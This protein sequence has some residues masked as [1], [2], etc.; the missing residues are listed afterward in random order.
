MKDRIIYALTIFT[1]LLYIIIANNIVLKGDK[2]FDEDEAS[3][4]FLSEVQKVISKTEL[5]YGEI[6]VSFEAKILKGEHKNEIVNALQIIDPSSSINYKELEVGE[7]IYL[8]KQTSDE[9]TIWYADQYDRA[10]GLIILGIVFIGFVLIF[11]RKK[12]VNTI[13][14]LIFTCLSIFMVYIPA[15]IKG[16]NIYFWSIITCI[17]IGVST[18][19]I[20]QGPTRKSFAAMFGCL[21]GTAISGILTLIMSEILS[22]TGMLNEESLYLYYMNA[23]NPIDLKGIIFG[24]IIVGAIGAIMDVSIDIASS[25]NE[26][27]NASEKPTF[28]KTIKAGFEIGRDIIGTMANTLVL[29]YIGSSLSC[30]LLTVSYSG[31][32][33]YLLNR[34]MIVVEM[35]Q[36][37]VG[38]LGIFLAIPLTT[39]ISA[40]LYLKTNKNHKFLPVFRKKEEKSKITKESFKENPW[41]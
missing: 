3:R 12:G 29:A 25:L 35:L 22:L 10:S 28:A 7:K 6:N 24:S 38:S 32:L 14:A 4:L 41:G 21:V 39:Y 26:V 34:E 27:I 13:V 20:V 19:L 16:Y 17:Y 15:I 9:G 40:F 11:G 1:A 23:E 33:T 36:A 18:L 31:S 2:F 5:E 8:Y 30:T 37:L